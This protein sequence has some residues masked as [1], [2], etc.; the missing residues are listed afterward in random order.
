M[1]VVGSIPSHILHYNDTIQKVNSS[2]LLIFEKYYKDLTNKLD[3]MSD[4]ESKVLELL[5]EFMNNEEKSGT[6]TD[7]MLFIYKVESFFLLFRI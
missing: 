3:D 5:M 7:R 2:L 6:D 4:I 1:V